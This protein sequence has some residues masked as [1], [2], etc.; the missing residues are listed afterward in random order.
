[1]LLYTALSFFLSHSY[2]SFS[3]FFFLFI[4]DFSLYSVLTFSSPHLRLMLTSWPS[5]TVYVYTIRAYNYCYHTL[6]HLCPSADE[7]LIPWFNF[8]LTCI[9]W[10][11]KKAW[12]DKHWLALSSIAIQT[13]TH[14]LRLSS[15]H[16]H[17]R[18][19]TRW[20]LVASLTWLHRGDTASV[21]L[22]AGISQRS[23]NYGT[24]NA[25]RR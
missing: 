9:L 18:P 2:F 5:A 19:C 7:C 22:T 21:T 25:D 1:M 16:P 10:K 23:T 11:K 15:P 20:R 17:I 3:L 4:H 12:H 6:S 13:N 14:T 8:I 24:L